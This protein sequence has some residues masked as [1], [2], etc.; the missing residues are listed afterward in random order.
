MSV[1]ASSIITRARLQLIDTGTTQRWTDT[2]LLYWL[3]DG[4]RAV[5]AA[6][7]HASQVTQSVLLVA[8]SRQTIPAGGYKLLNV[9]RNMGTTGTTPGQTCQ[10]VSREFMDA[11]YYTWPSDTASA[12]V[13]AWFMDESDPLGFYVYPQ[14]TGTSYI[15]LNYS[16]MPADLA[17]TTSTLNVQDIFQTALTDYVVARAHMKDSDY[18]AGAQIA[19]AWMQLF[20]QFVATQANK[21]KG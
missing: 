3:S 7:P 8:G 9:Y 19:A 17:A 10:K 20:E 14:N 12:I 21:Q 16:V 18:A 1:V 5:V 11:N 4:Q 15:E 2:E 13:R 6:V